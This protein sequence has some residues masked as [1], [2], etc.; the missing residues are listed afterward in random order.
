MI[1][2]RLQVEHFRCYNRPVEIVFDERLTVVA[3]LN[4]IG[5]ST[6]F[7]ALR[8]ALFRRTGAGGKDIGRLEPWGTTG[9]SAAVTVDF[10]LDGA[11]YQLRKS[12]GSGA[13]TCVLKRDRHGD[14]AP[15]KVE[16]A[17]EFV[18]G[19]FAGQPQKQGA[20]LRFTGQNVGLA[21]LLFAPQGAMAIAG[22]RKEIEL[23]A[24]ARARLTQIIGAAAQTPDAARLANKIGEDYARSFTPTGSVRNTRRRTRHRR[25]STQSSPRSRPP[26]RCSHA[27]RAPR[28]TSKPRKCVRRRQRARR[29]RLAPS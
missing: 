1:L 17:D 9:L 14:F 3:G 22:E 4:E 23:N 18:A 2:R 25:S 16:G 11:E 24:D 20:F 27:T 5:K 12:W 29:R 19:I 26:K 6:L 8:Y 28:T 15:Y 13:G 10:E 21:Y 7:D